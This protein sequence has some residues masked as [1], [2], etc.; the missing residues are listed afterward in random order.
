MTIYKVCM[1]AGILLFSNAVAA[2]AQTTSARANA[3]VIAV[4]PTEMEVSA[5]TSP[6]QLVMANDSRLHKE[7]SDSPEKPVRPSNKS[8]THKFGTQKSLDERRR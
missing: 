7:K 3:T 4:T 1:L 8:V 5:A 2:Q 6:N